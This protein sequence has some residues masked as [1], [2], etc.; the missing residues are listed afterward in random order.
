[1][2]TYAVDFRAFLLLVPD[3]KIMAV[4]SAGNIA[5]N[6]TDNSANA[7]APTSRSRR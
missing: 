2:R 6:I 5:D 3:I 4:S 1:L 7:A